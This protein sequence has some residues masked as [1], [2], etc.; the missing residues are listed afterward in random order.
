LGPSSQLSSTS[1]QRYRR[2]HGK[3]A[4]TNK[5]REKKHE[6]DGSIIDN[7]LSP[8]A[9]RYDHD[10]SSSCLFLV[11]FLQHNL[12]NKKPAMELLTQ[13]SNHVPSLQKRHPLDDFGGICGSI[14]PCF[15]L[16][17][18]SIGFWYFLSHD[19]IP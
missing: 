13:P 10:S 15:W 12:F 9:A 19:V 17:V 5:R 8:A 3:T 14:S 1:K 4:T 6:D 2:F 18:A 7:D 16:I 11:V